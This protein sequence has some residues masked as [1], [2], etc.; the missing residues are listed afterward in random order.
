MP[1]PR[2]ARGASQGL[3]HLMDQKRRSFFLVLFLWMD[4][5]EKVHPTKM[6]ETT[7][8]GNC[9]IIRPQ[10]GSLKIRDIAL[11]LLIFD[12]SGRNT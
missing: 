3:P 12:P 7:P 11:W 1:R 9:C 5:K 4:A 8:K 6:A 2:R 10:V